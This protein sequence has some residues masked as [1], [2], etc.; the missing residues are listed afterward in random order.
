VAD[1]PGQLP[2]G[3]LVVDAHMDRPARPGRGHGHQVLGPVG[4]LA[5]DPVSGADAQAAV[6]AGQGQDLLLEPAIGQ[7]A[8]AVLECH[9]L[10]PTP[11]R[12]LQRPRQGIRAQGEP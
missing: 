12:R 4:Q 8:V 1:Q 6:G 5:R 10:G 9:P 7:R 2:S 3:E 11:P